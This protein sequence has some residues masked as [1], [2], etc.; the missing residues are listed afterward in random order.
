MACVKSCLL[1]RRTTGKHLHLKDFKAEIGQGQ[2]MQG[3]DLVHKRV[4]TKSEN[5]LDQE[6]RNKMKRNP[7][8]AAL[9][10]KDLQL[11]NFTHDMYWDQ[12][13]QH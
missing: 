1:W 9:Q 6:I 10:T 5:Q 13:R 7:A 8:T 2:S 12:S 11:D 4:R 3:K